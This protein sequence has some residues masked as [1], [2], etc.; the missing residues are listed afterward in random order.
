MTLLFV[1]VHPLLTLESRKSGARRNLSVY[2]TTIARHL[3]GKY[4]P[5]AM[6]THMTEEL[7]GMSFSMQFMSH[8]RK[9]FMSVCVSLL[10]NG[11][12]NMFP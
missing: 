1:S 11:F 8:H 5:V 6:N 7:L 3:L 2:P 10:G 12:L 9:V 4:V